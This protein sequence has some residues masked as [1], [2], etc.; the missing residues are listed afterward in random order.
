MGPGNGLFSPHDFSWGANAANVLVT[1]V[2]HDCMYSTPQQLSISC[3]S[4]R[5]SRECERLASETSDHAA[6]GTK[7]NDLYMS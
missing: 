7:S 5:L 6:G 4:T 2:L 1:C 3:I